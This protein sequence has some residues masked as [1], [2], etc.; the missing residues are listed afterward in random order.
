MI[1][2]LNIMMYALFIG[3]VAI[4]VYPPE[5]VIRYVMNNEPVDSIKKNSM[6]FSIVKGAPNM[7]NNMV[8]GMAI[9]TIRS[10]IE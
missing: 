8:R 3:Y 10:N 1:K 4:G 5:I 6:A 9:D 7:M 2:Q